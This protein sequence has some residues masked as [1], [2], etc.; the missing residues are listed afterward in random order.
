MNRRNT[1]SYTVRVPRADWPRIDRAIARLGDVP[2]E[3]SAVRTHHG[4]LTFRAVDDA[5]ATALAKHVM[6]GD[7]HRVTVGLGIH[8]RVVSITMGHGE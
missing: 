8:H 4:S 6:E 1:T 3:A 2:L 7:A 5:A